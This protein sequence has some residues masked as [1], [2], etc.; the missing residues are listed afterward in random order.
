MADNQELTSGAYIDKVNQK[1]DKAKNMNKHS[2]VK[3]ILLGSII[4]I[5]LIIAWE[6][7]CRAGIVPSYQLPAP[8][9]IVEKKFITWPKM[10]HYG[11]TLVLRHI[12]CLL[13]LF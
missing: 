11:G 1:D 13:D 4:P 5:L 9:T 7:V 2:T 12:E 10:V 6:L 3:T 8:S